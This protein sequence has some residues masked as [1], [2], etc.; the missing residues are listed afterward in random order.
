MLMPVPRK[1]WARDLHKLLD[2]QNRAWL[3]A[4]DQE[5]V[6]D[7]AILFSMLYSTIQVATLWFRGAIVREDEQ[8]VADGKLG[9]S[10]Y[11]GFI[12]R[13]E[14]VDPTNAVKRRGDLHDQYHSLDDL[15]T[16]MEK[17][18]APESSN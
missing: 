17:S 1:Q 16:S 5:R 15:L 14:E 18:I 13:C 3:E 12:S 4:V 10:D 9:W 11:A 2:D 6:A 7:A 8:A